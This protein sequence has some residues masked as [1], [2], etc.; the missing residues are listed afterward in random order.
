VRCLTLVIHRD[1]LFDGVLRRA[2]EED[3]VLVIKNAVLGYLVKRRVQRTSI[4]LQFA[5]CE[6]LYLSIFDLNVPYVG[7]SSKLRPIFAVLS[8][9]P[10]TFSGFFDSYR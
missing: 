5:F 6:G 1:V 9:N 4:I 10:N 7:F 8:S 3:T 2:L